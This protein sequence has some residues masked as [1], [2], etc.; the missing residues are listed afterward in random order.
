MMSLVV[1]GWLN[2][3]QPGLIQNQAI[4][5]SPSTHALPLTPSVALSIVYVPRSA[6][7]S[8]YADEMASSCNQAFVTNIA[9]QQQP[10]H[11]ELI[12]WLMIA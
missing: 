5:K 8:A 12:L 1:Q 3:W 10:T 11:T 7:S 4:S 6:I 9:S 2:Q